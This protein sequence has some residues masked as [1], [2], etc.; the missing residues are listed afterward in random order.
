MSTEETLNKDLLSNIVGASDDVNPTKVLEVALKAN[1]AKLL[2]GVM[3]SEDVNPIKV[4][5]KALRANKSTLVTR[6]AEASDI[7]SKA[8]ASR[9]MGVLVDA[10]EDL[11]ATAAKAPAE[12]ILNVVLDGVRDLDTTPSKAAGSRVTDLV[13]NTIKDALVA[14][15]DVTLSGFVNMKPAVQAAKPAREGRNPATGEAMSIAAVPAKNVV[16]MKVT[17]PFKRELNA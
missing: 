6:L 11:D 8:A 4:L 3:A 2:A 9:I 1:K 10:I 13:I 14:G 5:A 16:R 15:K 7:E 12:R 17:A